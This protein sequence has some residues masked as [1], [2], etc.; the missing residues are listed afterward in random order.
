MKPKSL[1][2]HCRITAATLTEATMIPSPALQTVVQ[3]AFDRA[4]AVIG[5][6][7]SEPG[8]EERVTAMRQ[9]Q[10]LYNKILANQMEAVPYG[11]ID[12][13]SINPVMRSWWIFQLF[14]TLQDLVEWLNSGDPELTEVDMALEFEAIAPE[15][16]LKSSLYDTIFPGFKISPAARRA[17]R[18][19]HPLNSPSPGNVV[20]EIN[21]ELGR[22][23]VTCQ[24]GF[25][26]ARLPPNVRFDQTTQIWDVVPV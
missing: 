14:E 21:Q 5:Q 22:I 18:K 2:F 1:G 6:K 8:N 9:L 17:I 25:T 19:E 4:N 26:A 16:R 7:A 23:T 3:Q 20:E 10:E 12:A 13:D 24:A 11:V 15:R